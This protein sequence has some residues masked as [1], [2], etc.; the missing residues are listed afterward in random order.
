MRQQAVVTRVLLNGMAEIEV[1]RASACGHDCSKC[2]GCGTAVQ[3]RIRAIARNEARAQL[4][5]I[6]T[7]EGDT[8]K[9]FGAAA[10]VYILPLVLFLAV[11]A[12]A[13]V[14]GLADSMAALV[15]A[16]GFVA[17][18]LCAMGYNRYVQRT[19]NIRFVIIQCETVIER[20]I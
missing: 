13:R 7:I 14:G 20:K 8:K 18:I 19:G 5:D 12:M 16:S 15:G 3:Q 1:A 10:M 11:Y 6:V 4:G 17:G 2:G 9:V